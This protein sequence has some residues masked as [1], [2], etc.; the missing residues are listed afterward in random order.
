MICAVNDRPRSTSFAGYRGL[1]SERRRFTV[2]R[3]WRRCGISSRGPVWPWNR[4]R[5]WSRPGSYRG[6]SLYDGALVSGLASALKLRYRVQRR[7]YPLATRRPHEAVAARAGPR[8][9]R[10]GVG[11]GADRGS[12]C[13]GAGGRLRYRVE[14]GRDDRAGTAHVARQQDD[15]AGPALLGIATHPRG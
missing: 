3:F 7:Y 14:A 15:L 13:G 10:H 6:E 4:P 1:A 12:Y 9:Q 8:D 2:N 11:F 5:N